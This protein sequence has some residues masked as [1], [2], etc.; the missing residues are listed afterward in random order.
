M[1]TRVLTITLGPELV[2]LVASA[3]DSPPDGA[4]SSRGPRGG[5][6]RVLAVLGL[7]S[8]TSQVRVVYAYVL[9]EQLLCVV[10]ALS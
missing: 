9:L 3:A 10:G 2:A 8:R 6:I 5:S 1:G 4:G 7:L